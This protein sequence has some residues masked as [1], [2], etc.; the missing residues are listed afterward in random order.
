VSV[1]RMED[2]YPSG[3]GCIWMSHENSP[4]CQNDD[5]RRSGQGRSNLSHVLENVFF[6]LH[7]QGA[8]IL[9]TINPPG[10]YQ[11]LLSGPM[12]PKKWDSFV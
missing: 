8:W 5:L 10:S 12:N 3:G 6:L 4:G 1:G 11:Y 9:N 7:R 2:T